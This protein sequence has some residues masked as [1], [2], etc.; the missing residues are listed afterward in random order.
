MP[1]HRSRDP[2]GAGCQSMTP[3]ASRGVPFPRATWPGGVGGLACTGVRARPPA[4]RRCQSLGRRSCLVGPPTPAPKRRQG[5]PGDRRASR[6]TSAARCTV[7]TWAGARATPPQDATEPSGGA[8]AASG[9]LHR[10]RGADFTIRSPHH[11]GRASSAACSRRTVGRSPPRAWSCWPADR[12][13]A[14]LAGPG[15]PGAEAQVE[16]PDGMRRQP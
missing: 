12:R 7:V 10:R 8:R 3:A 5:W 9:R 13:T 2:H 16:P 15:L 6:S 4:A 1:K 11:T 14:S